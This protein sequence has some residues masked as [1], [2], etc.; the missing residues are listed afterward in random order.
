[1]KRHLSLLPTSAIRIFNLLS[2][3]QG[4]KIQWVLLLSNAANGVISYYP[5]KK[6]WKVINNMN[7]WFHKDGIYIILSIK[8]G[9]K[10][11]SK[12]RR[13]WLGFNF[14]TT[15][16]KTRMNLRLHPLVCALAWFLSISIKTRIE[17]YY[18]CEYKKFK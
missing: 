17:T 8:Q 12:N 10:P 9:L 13:L 7:C 11:G 1:M 2:L 3:K 16:I 15:I 6:D 4:L 14:I 5:W 18:Y